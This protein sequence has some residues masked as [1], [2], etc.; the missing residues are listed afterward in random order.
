M[1]IWQEL[2]ISYSQW[3]QARR[4]LIAIAHKICFRICTG[5]VPGNQEELKVNGTHHL[6]VY[7][8]DIKPVGGNINTISKTQEKK[9]MFLS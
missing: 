2:A 7:I 8:D 6:L 3:S 9:C 1:L 4:W 5:I